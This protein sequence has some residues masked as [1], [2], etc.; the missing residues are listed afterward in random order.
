V[1][2]APGWLYVATSLHA[3]HLPAWIVAG[4]ASAPPVSLWSA[5]GDGGKRLLCYLLTPALWRTLTRQLI[6]LDLAG[7]VPREKV[8]AA[9][10]RLARL[11]AYAAAHGW[12]LASGTDPEGSPS[13][14][15]PDDSGSLPS[16]PVALAVLESVV[17]YFR[18][19]AGPTRKWDP[20][21]QRFAEVPPDRGGR[22]ELPE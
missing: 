2:A 15:S 6:A 7:R 17:K 18:A 1:N 21:T 8:A 19:P 10:A 14:A 3:A 12:M 20:K 9:V 5:C 22:E 4:T 16:A 11:D 13:A